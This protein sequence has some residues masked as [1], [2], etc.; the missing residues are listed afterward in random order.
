MKPSI[1]ITDVGQL[2][3]E[4]N[5]YKKGRKLTLP[6]FNQ[7]ARLAWL[8]KIALSPLDPEDPECAAFLLY[9]ERPDGLAGHFLDLDEDLMSRIHVLDAEQGGHLAEII[10]EGV[11]ERAAQYQALNRRDF[12]FG[13]YFNPDEA[14]NAE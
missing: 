4:L 3:N 12:Y 5:K 9:L 11:A 8:G 10:K 6:Q 1:K 14:K 7:A 2:R 13:R